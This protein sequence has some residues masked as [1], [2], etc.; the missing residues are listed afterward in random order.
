MM[1]L[2]PAEVEQSSGEIVTSHLVYPIVDVSTL[3]LEELIA[4]PTAGEAPN[5]AVSP[6]L[7]MVDLMRCIQWEIVVRCDLK[8]RIGMLV[9]IFG[10][11][12]V[13]CFFVSF[14]KAED[15]MMMVVVAA[16]EEFENGRLLL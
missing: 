9:D 8:A 3:K 1:Q 7:L 10:D 11:A 2:Y 13:R 15:Y 6:G 14:S 4:D 16:V 12:I 5:W